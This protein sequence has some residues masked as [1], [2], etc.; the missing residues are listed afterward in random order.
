MLTQITEETMAIS[1]IWMTTAFS[2]RSYTLK[3]KITKKKIHPNNKAEDKAVDFLGISFLDMFS[4]AAAG[5]TFSAGT[6]CSQT[7]WFRW[8]P[9]GCRYW[10]GSALRWDQDCSEGTSINCWLPTKP[11]KLMEAFPINLGISFSLKRHLTL[12]L[13]EATK[14]GWCALCHRSWLCSCQNT[15]T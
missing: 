9:L 2:G 13:S 15:R 4:A 7:F 10:L 14:Q 12:S 6:C 8:C 5:V 11:H 1:Q 3:K